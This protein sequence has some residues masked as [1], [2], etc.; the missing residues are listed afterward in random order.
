M[1]LIAWAGRLHEKPVAE[2]LR[3]RR[4]QV[5]DELITVTECRHIDMAKYEELKDEERWINAKLEMLK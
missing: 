5:Y 1:L 4:G 2:M 3:K